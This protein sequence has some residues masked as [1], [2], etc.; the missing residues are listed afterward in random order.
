MRKLDILNQIL[1]KIQEQDNA[2]DAI[3]TEPVLDPNAPPPTDMGGAVGEEPVLPL[4]ADNQFFGQLKVGDVFTDLD[5]A[6]IKYKVISD[7]VSDTETGLVTSL[8]CEVVEAPEGN[9]KGVAIGDPFDAISG[10][11]GKADMEMPPED[12]FPVDAPPEDAPPEDVSPE[13]PTESKGKKFKLGK[14]KT[15]P[16]QPEKKGKRGEGYSLKRRFSNI[17]ETLS[18]GMVQEIRNEGVVVRSGKWHRVYPLVAGAKVG[19]TVELEGD[20]ITKVIG[21][22]DAPIFSKVKS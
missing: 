22:Q 15:A 5:D 7:P 1:V 8:P 9:S 4:A 10:M 21:S 2:V 13:I 11:P 14:S 3:S 18:T 17:R 20:K 6:T 16:K 19:D 12:E